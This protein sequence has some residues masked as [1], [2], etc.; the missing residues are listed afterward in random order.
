M[1]RNNGGVQRR[2]IDVGGRKPLHGAVAARAP[3][4]NIAHGNSVGGTKRSGND[5]AQITEQTDWVNLTKGMK[6]CEYTYG[7]S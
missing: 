7:F 1:R 3:A 5:G 2:P 4:G 6:E